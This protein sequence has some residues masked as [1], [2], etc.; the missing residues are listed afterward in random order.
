MTPQRA[1]MM[2]AKQLGN[3]KAKLVNMKDQLLLHAIQTRNPKHKIAD[4]V[5]GIEGLFEKVVLQVDN[6]FVTQ[7]IKESG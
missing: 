6:E 7:E 2:K 5:S 4:I 1:R 3:M